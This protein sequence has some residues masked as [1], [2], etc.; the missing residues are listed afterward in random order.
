MF[1]DLSGFAP[2]HSIVADSVEN[3][4][5][6]GAWH[7]LKL[8]RCNYLTLEPLRMS[9]P[10]GRLGVPEAIYGK[11]PSGQRQLIRGAEESLVRGNFLH[12]T[13]SG[14]V[15]QMV[16]RVV[17]AAMEDFMATSNG[18]GLRPGETAPRS[19]QYEQI[20][21]RG[22]R[23]GDERTVTRGETLPPTPRPNM[24][25]TLVDATKHGKR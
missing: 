25:Y 16:G 2:I 18:R 23:T 10:T 24:S 8:Q 13:P 6:V 20:G 1:P 14:R 22:G 12:G 9:D 19:G 3:L 4:W 15:H 21:P 17:L 5:I 11:S 7:G